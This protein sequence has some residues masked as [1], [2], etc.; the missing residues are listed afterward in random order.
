MGVLPGFL[1]PPPNCSP[2]AQISADCVGREY[3][4]PSHTCISSP[5]AFSLQN[6]K[7]TQLVTR[8][9]V[10]NTV[11]CRGR[12]DGHVEGKIL[13]C[14]L[15]LGGS[16]WRKEPNIMSLSISSSFSSYNVFSKADN[17]NM[18]WKKNCSQPACMFDQCAVYQFKCQVVFF[19]TL[20]GSLGNSGQQGP[21]KVRT[22]RSGPS[23]S[24]ASHSK[25]LQL[26]GQMRLL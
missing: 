23:E 22:L 5:N 25:E 7:H 6:H 12:C 20:M 15:N 16:L 17:V 13:K 4:S 26:Q 18:E 11:F 1:S 14:C 21:Q 19:L 24:S 9:E 8:S 10:E 2:S 3:L